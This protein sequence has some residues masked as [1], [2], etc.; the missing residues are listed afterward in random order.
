[1]IGHS[2]ICKHSESFLPTFYIISVR[3]SVSN[4]NK[5]FRSGTRQATCDCSTTTSEL[6]TQ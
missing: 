1:M 3:M 5:M 2:Y 4:G 6:Q